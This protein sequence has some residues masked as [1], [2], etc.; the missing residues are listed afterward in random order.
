MVLSCKVSIV[1]KGK[2]TCVTKSNF[3]WHVHGALI[4]D[5]CRMIL[6][7]SRFVANSFLLQ[8]GLVCVCEF[9]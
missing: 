7:R 1:V 9:V 8:T 3:C 5:S 2:L 4:G 6:F